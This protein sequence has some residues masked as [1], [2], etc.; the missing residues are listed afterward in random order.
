MEFDWL[1]W[2]AA[3]RFF[4]TTLASLGEERCREG[5]RAQR[6]GDGEVGKHEPGA[7]LHPLYPVWGGGVTIAACVLV[8]LLAAALF[9]VSA[10]RQSTSTTTSTTKPPP[11]F[12]SIEY[13]GKRERQKGGGCH[14]R[15][16]SPHTPHRRRRRRLVG[17]VASVPTAVAA[18]LYKTI[19]V[20]DIGDSQHAPALVS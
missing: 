10:E 11:V 13:R 19:F 6:S 5:R 4:H 14:T 15:T 8:L 7:L 16:P 20:L 1:L 18:P 2:R 17:A 12:S 3:T 9:H